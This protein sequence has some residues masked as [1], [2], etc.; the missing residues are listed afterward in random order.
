MESRKTFSGVRFALVGFNPIDG[1]TVLISL[2]LSIFNCSDFHV[3]GF[4]VKFDFDI[5]SLLQLRSKLLSGG[6][7]D[8]GHYNQTCTHLIV[9]MLVYVSLSSSSF[10][11]SLCFV[12]WKIL[13]FGFGVFFDI[14]GWSNLCCCSKQWEGGCHRLMGWS[15]FRYWNAYWF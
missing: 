15:Q 11:S 4:W 13:T 12:G 7:V 1:N 9:D 14:I 3:K 6:G 5:I 2:S 10:V 8:V